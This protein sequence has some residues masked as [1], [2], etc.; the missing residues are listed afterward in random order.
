MFDASAFGAAG[1][2]ETDDTA[3]LQKAI[4]TA[5]QV[6]GTVFLPKGFY[7]ISRTLNMTA[8]ALVG[9][10]RSLSVLMP[11]SEGLTGMGVSTPSPVLHVPASGAGKAPAPVVVEMLSI[12]VWEHSDNVWALW[13]EN[14][15]PDSVY[16]QCYFYRIT[17]CFFGFPHPKPVPVPA[18]QPTIPCKP[19]ADLEHPLN[20][21][22]GGGAGRFYNFENEDFLYE[23]ASYRHLLVQ[24]TQGPLWLYNMNFEHASS[25][26]NVEFRDAGNV[27]V[28]SLKSEG[29]WRDLVFK[30]G[31]KNPAVALWVRNCSEVNVFS[32]G[33]NARPRKTGDTYPPG[34]AQFPP[35]LYRLEDSCPLRITN[36]VD[37]FQF[38]PDNDWNFILER[39]GGSEVLTGHCERPVLFSRQACRRGS[40]GQ[41]VASLVV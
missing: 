2:G 7:R 11:M 3:A 5:A 37:Q 28:Y 40:G 6:H 38:A 30:G 19:A 24:G 4:D 17:E 29:E 18:T 26:A 39:Y 34:F 8:G 14:E 33:G 41:E 32:F 21:I 23:S 20:V 31:L 35:S 1:D 12:V 27:F 13:W 15:H 16:R 10:A 36:C 25:E 9:A 22:S